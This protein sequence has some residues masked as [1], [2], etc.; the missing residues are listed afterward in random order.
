MKQYTL[1]AVIILAG[2]AL[3]AAVWMYYQSAQSAKQTADSTQDL[4][5]RMQ[6]ID[7]DQ[8]STPDASGGD[9]TDSDSSFDPMDLDATPPDTEPFVA[10]TL[11]FF[12]PGVRVKEYCSSGDSAE[13]TLADATRSQSETMN[14]LQA[15]LN[16]LLR[17]TDAYGAD[18]RP[19]DSDVELTEFNRQRIACE[20]VE[21]YGDTEN[22]DDGYFY[23]V[24]KEHMESGNIDRILRQQR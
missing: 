24:V 6:G 19:M 13:L 11:C 18:I 2:A 20:Y 4:M 22:F 1:G 16:E 21:L 14:E 10:H 12:Q 5:L 17:N 7:P 23:Y 3:L 15:C 9:E 8:S